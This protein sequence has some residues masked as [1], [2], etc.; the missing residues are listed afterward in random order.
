MTRASTDGRKG[1]NPRPPTRTSARETH[2][3]SRSTRKSLRSAPLQNPS[4]VIGKRR[5]KAK[6]TKYDPLEE[7]PAVTI[8]DARLVERN[9]ES[10]KEYLIKWKR[11]Q[12]GEM[13]S[14]TWE[15]CENA[16]EALRADYESKTGKKGVRG[17]DYAERAPPADSW[18]QTA[19]E[20]ASDETMDIH[21]T[22]WFSLY[23]DD[24]KAHNY[25]A[26]AEPQNTTQSRSATEEIEGNKPPY[27]GQTFVAPLA[28]SNSSLLKTHDVP[29][30]LRDVVPTQD[31]HAVCRNGPSVAAIIARGSIAG[32][33]IGRSLRP[34]GKLPSIPRRYGK[35]IWQEDLY[36]VQLPQKQRR[37]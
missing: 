19:A 32:T 2:E 10:S 31:K 6:Q 33:Q 34:K 5:G 17:P 14:P 24:A 9:G 35:R 25:R 15:P 8:L 26:V 28:Y 21:R 30:V 23:V 7:W 16:N 1:D 37:A 22:D 29:Q 20:N 13:Y 36:L 12:M 3:T 18:E 11:G 27:V 4:K